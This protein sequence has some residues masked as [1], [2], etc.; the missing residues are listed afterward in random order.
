MPSFDIRTLLNFNPPHFMCE[1]CR[2]L[3]RELPI[4]KERRLRYCPVCKIEYEPT[5]EISIYNYEKYMTTFKLNIDIKNQLGQS[6]RL[7][8]IA[9]NFLK[10]ERFPPIYTMLQAVHAAQSFV[11]F[12]SYGLSY[13]L[14][15]ALKMASF[16]IP[17]R[18]IVS[19]IS[20]DFAQEIKKNEREAPNLN[21]VVF[22]RSNHKEDW[23]S[24]PHQKLIVIDGLLAF[25]G[26]ANMTEMGWRKVAEGKD[27]AEPVTDLN[28]IADLHNKLFSPI[29]GDCNAMK[30]P[31][32]MEEMP[33]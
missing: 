20:S 33:F 13:Q 31:I 16:S 9:S 6:Q 12:T 30:G 17:I 24:A 21:L 22:E 14:Y 8:L 26:A 2:A 4:N 1:N 29:W 11:H 3:L 25:K 5:E 19:N 28:E 15:G 7:A 23:E 18:G 32:V 10:N 27:H